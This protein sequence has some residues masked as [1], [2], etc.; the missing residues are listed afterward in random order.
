[1][2]D[3]EELYK[4]IDTINHCKVLYQFA[5]GEYSQCAAGDVYLTP[6]T[7]DPVNSD[8]KIGGETYEIHL[9]N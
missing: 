8:I 9:N 7:I 1:M 2:N 6:F 4:D 3:L 5:S